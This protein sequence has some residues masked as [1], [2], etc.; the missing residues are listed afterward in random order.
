MV[1][2]AV[3]TGIAD[4]IMLSVTPTESK[5]EKYEREIFKSSCLTWYMY[6]IGSGF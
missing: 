3:G 1:S 4:V 2:K 5:S 6:Y